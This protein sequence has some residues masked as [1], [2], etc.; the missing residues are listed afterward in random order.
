MRKA[1][2]LAM[3]VSVVMLFLGG[4]V[5]A[6]QS[7]PWSEI[8]E[9]LLDGEGAEF[10]KFV[11]VPIVGETEF[12]KVQDAADYVAGFFGQYVEDVV[13]TWT[14]AD[15]FETEPVLSGSRDCEDFAIYLCAIVRYVIGV[16]ASRVWVSINLVTEPGVGVVAG[17]A[18]VGYKLERGGNV[19][20]EPQT[21]KIYRGRAKG[22]LN[23]NDEWVKGGGFYLHGPIE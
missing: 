3:V 14:A 10:V 16:P 8:R 9:D 12:E 5:L 15:Q 21:G 6:Y 1:L 2:V 11:S 20:I 19:Y 17:H 4:S 7:S 23:F 18:W 22:M 13:E